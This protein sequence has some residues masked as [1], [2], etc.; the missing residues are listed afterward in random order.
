MLR[1]ARHRL[2]PLNTLRFFEATARHGSF[3]RAAGELCVTA[4]AVSRQ[5]KALEE[6]LGVA[7]FQRHAQRLEI[8]RTGEKLLRKVQ[9]AFSSIEQ[10]TR[11]IEIDKNVVRI[12][13]S[14]NL[15]VRWLSSRLHELHAEFP[16]LR[17]MID[18]SPQLSDLAAD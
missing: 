7:L 2:P 5:V 1:S 8:T 4:G 10:E 18:A 6:S 9:D 3:A 12:G 17:L 13:L 11:R 14:P 15:A 16:S